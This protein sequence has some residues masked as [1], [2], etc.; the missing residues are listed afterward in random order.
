MAL[1]DGDDADEVAGGPDTP[2]TELVARASFVSAQPRCRLLFNPSP[3]AWAVRS[4]RNV[5]AYQ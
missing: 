4:A 2:A 1:A 3:R 5:F